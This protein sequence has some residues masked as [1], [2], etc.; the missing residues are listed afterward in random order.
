MESRINSQDV[1][2]HSLGQYRIEPWQRKNLHRKQ[3]F[4][5]E[6]DISCQSQE[7]AY[8]NRNSSLIQTMGFS[9]LLM[10]LH[11]LKWGH[12]KRKPARFS[13]KFDGV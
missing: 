6:L 12:G 3:I 4:Q 2:V 13:K 11:F 7:I 9:T 5:D 8:F 1:E 10:L